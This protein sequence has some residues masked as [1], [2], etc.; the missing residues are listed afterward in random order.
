MPTNLLISKAF[1]LPLLSE[2][3]ECGA[4]KPPTSHFWACE[5]FGLTLRSKTVS[6]ASLYLSLISPKKVGGKLNSTRVGSLVAT[7]IPEEPKKA[8][9]P[10]FLFKDSKYLIIF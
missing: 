10:Q 2:L 5:V 3:S 7:P 4:A 1:G 8:I 9:S 6:T